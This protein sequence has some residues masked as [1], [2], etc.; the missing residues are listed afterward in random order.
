MG[1]EKRTASSGSREQH[2]H[3][4]GVHLQELRGG[5]P[6]FPTCQKEYWAYKTREKHGRFLPR[7][8]ETTNLENFFCFTVFKSL[9]LPRDPG[10][11]PAARGKKR[12]G[13]RMVEAPPPVWRFPQ[14]PSANKENT[15]AKSR[16]Q[17]IPSNGNWVWEQKTAK[18]RKKAD[19]RLLQRLFEVE[20]RGSPRVRA[21]SQQ[22]RS[23]SS[24]ANESKP[25]C[26]SKQGLPN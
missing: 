22:A 23:E 4:K 21:N 10:S 1:Q 13:A 18:F 6:L 26:T 24:I 19:R 16:A 11:I 25:F 7:G 2:H 14:R 17:V 20:T 3:Q 15:S 5:K 9:P 8:A 12:F